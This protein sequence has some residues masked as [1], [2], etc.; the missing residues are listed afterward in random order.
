MKNG[1]NLIKLI[2]FA[3]LPGHQLVYRG[4][5]HNLYLRVKGMASGGGETYYN[6]ILGGYMVEPEAL[7]RRSSSKKALAKLARKLAYKLDLNYFDSADKSR[8]HIVRHRCPYRQSAI[9]DS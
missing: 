5:L 8:S 7:T 1:E 3:H 2:K 9:A 4:H 6:V